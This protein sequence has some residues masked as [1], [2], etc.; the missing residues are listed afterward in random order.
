M[1]VDAAST[2]SGRHEPVPIHRT[3][4]ANQGQGM[5]ETLNN[6][7][8]DAAEGT[9][10]DGAATNAA[11]ESWPQFYGRPE[12][13]H[14]EHHGTWRIQPGDVAFAAQANSVPVMAGE[15]A[16]AARHYPL[17][18]A[19]AER[20]P[21]AVVGLGRGNG[22]VEEGVWTQGAYVPAYVRRYPFVFAEV[23]G[24][25]ALAVDA[26]A[27]M[28]SKDGETGEPLFVDG[29]PSPVTRQALQFCDAFTREN[30]ATRE[31]VRLLVEQNLLVERTA[32]I[33]L[34]QGERSSLGGF[35]V[36]DPEAF[37]TL[38]ESVIVEW[39]RKGWLALVHAHLGSL[40]RFADLLA[41]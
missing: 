10:E 1:Q 18:F 34:P 17:V 28:L 31:L 41:K 5:S 19:G 15:F 38:S 12:L 2:C 16:A 37:A 21:V 35:A 8:V 39:H 30:A 27:P 36:V 4:I 20:V 6:T 11:S 3:H 13:L 26:D 25:F 40:A 14:A 24:G 33:T 29:A 32:N 9:T 7:A 22:F 23:E